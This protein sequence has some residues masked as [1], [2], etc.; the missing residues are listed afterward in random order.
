MPKEDK[1][2]DWQHTPP[3]P[4][5]LRG[6]AQYGLSFRRA[7]P[8]GLGL[9]QPPSLYCDAFCWEKIAKRDFPNAFKILSALF[10]FL[11]SRDDDS[12]EEESSRCLLF[13]RPLVVFVIFR[14]ELVDLLDRE[15]ERWRDGDTLLRMAADDE[16]APLVFCVLALTASP[17]PCSHGSLC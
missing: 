12:L 8:A 5:L 6:I 17:S 4:L 13:F 9:A 2:G 11:I 1:S 14:A 15:R 10:I 3:N 16:A 7:K